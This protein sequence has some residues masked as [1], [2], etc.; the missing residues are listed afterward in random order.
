MGN[1]N[2]RWCA[3]LVLILGIM[4]ICSPAKLIAYSGIDELWPDKA[5][6][7]ITMDLQ[8]VSLRDALKM[9]SVQSGMNFIASEA[10]AERKL[11]L[12]LDNVPLRDALDKIFKVN[13]LTYDLDEQGNIFTVK[14]WGKPSLELDTRVYFLKYIRVTNSRLNQGL[15]AAES[16]STGSSS[17]AAASQTNS[18]SESSSASTATANGL[19]DALKSVVS[20]YGKLI[21]DPATNSMIVTDMP[22]KFSVIEQLIAKLDVPIPQLMIEVEI[23]DVD[24]SEIDKLGV[25]WPNSIAQL[26]V[27]GSRDTKFPFGAGKGT[28]AQGRKIDPKEGVFGGPGAGWDFG[29]W[30]AAH[31]GPSILTVIGSTLALDL[32]KSISSTKFL[33]RPKLFVLNNETAEVR[34][35]SNEAIG[36]GT[37]TQGQGT[38]SSTTVSAERAET[39]VTLQ[40]TPQI[41]MATG[42]ITMIL[43]PSVKEAVLSGITLDTT[44]TAKSSQTLKDVEERSVKSTVRVRDGE[45]VILGGLIRNK[46]VSAKTRVPFL[47]NIPI[48][49]IIF[50]HKDTSGSKD[51]EILVF[52]TPKIMRGSGQLAAGVNPMVSKMLGGRKQDEFISGSTALSPGPERQEIVSRAL[53]RYE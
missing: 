2:R 28:S 9:L 51:R 41:S 38:S 47:G 22:S 30:G 44:G 7:K 12:Y 29:E 52:I 32:L 5:A 40:V 33:A 16:S 23:L 39:G 24:K 43:R 17:S 1:K 3:V 50:R 34:L 49:G 14:D 36:S 27:P 25:R 13:N 37:T 48:L 10:V 46:D 20:E 11:T 35:S 18:S 42:E 6:V 45:T 19:K 21:E 15:A 26:T 31:F 8:D 53:G 4:S